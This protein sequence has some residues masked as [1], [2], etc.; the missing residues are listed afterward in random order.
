VQHD[1][2]QVGSSPAKDTA[3]Q[4]PADSDVQHDDQQQVGSK[5]DCSVA[6]L[7]H[8]EFDDMS[9]L[10]KAAQNGSLPDAIELVETILDVC[11][12]MEN[13]VLMPSETKPPDEVEKYMSSTMSLGTPMK[14]CEETAALIEP[15]DSPP[16]VPFPS[17]LDT[18]QKVE[19]ILRESGVRLLSDSAASAR[20]DDPWV[21][22]V[23]NLKGECIFSYQAEKTTT[24]R[25]WKEGKVER[26]RMRKT[27]SQR[28]Q[29]AFFH[30]P[31]YLV[32]PF[33]DDEDKK[34]RTALYYAV[35]HDEPKTTRG[36]IVDLLLRRGARFGKGAKSDKGI[37]ARSSEYV[38]RLL[39]NKN[40]VPGTTQERGLPQLRCTVEEPRNDNKW[41]LF[42]S[43]AQALSQQSIFE[44]VRHLE[45]LTE[46]KIKIWT[47]QV[48]LARDAPTTCCF[49]CSD[50]AKAP[51]RVI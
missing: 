39:V 5:N 17:E 9:I 28:E 7:L 22:D 37:P 33:L 32:N 8:T 42:M 50:S 31:R 38:E 35:L 46:N 20:T 29:P 3:P 49:H 48:R 34:G 30:R 18:S 19:D 27:K 24:V 40:L 23:V 12:F 45:E 44:V 47:D 25:K 15:E 10:M 16:G 26:E 11:D 2:Q 21:V 36:K 43:H 6:G 13:Y 1:D 4:Q 14:R 41:H 51:A